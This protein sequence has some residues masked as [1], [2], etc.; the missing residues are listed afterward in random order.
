MTKQENRNSMDNH[1]LY[2]FEKDE[3]ESNSL[4][5]IIQTNNYQKYKKCLKL[6]GNKIKRIKS[7]TTP[8]QE[9]TPS[10]SKTNYE[11][12][13]SPKNFDNFN[14]VNNIKEIKLNVT[15]CLCEQIIIEL[16]DKYINQNTILMKDYMKSLKEFDP[17][18]RIILMD[19]VMAICASNRFKRETFHMTVSLI[20][21]CLTKLK[22]ISIDKIQLLA[23]TCLL[24]SS[25]YLEV[26]IPSIKQY[27]YFTAET[28]SV[29]EIKYYEIVILNLLDWKIN[30]VDIYQWSN[31]ILY[32]WKNYLNEYSNLFQINEKD[33]NR[34]Y[35]LYYYILDCIILDYYYRF[36]NMKFLCLTLI[37]L[38][39]GYEFGIFDEEY[40]NLSEI[41][42]KYYNYLFNKFVE[43]NEIFG[44]ANFR[45]YIPYVLKF[46]NKKI[47]SAINEEIK[48]LN[49][50]IF[51]QDYD[52]NKIKI[53]KNAIKNQFYFYN[54]KK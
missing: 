5:K 54:N 42:Y 41:K 31:L 33:I 45:K 1:D 30:Y 34:L 44:L 8:K 9:K 28:Y 39:F 6:L 2:I 7:K 51:V 47:I 38:L 16:N 36:C 37:Y 14:Q 21:I 25:K 43:K 11:T 46:I 13:I 48:H 12:P 50:N 4:D 35:I 49:N 20:D 40:F 18:K 10:K 29:Q 19:W 26:L 15:S 23:T 53:A 52:E 32:K 22:Q 24:I 17:F 27:S 3:D